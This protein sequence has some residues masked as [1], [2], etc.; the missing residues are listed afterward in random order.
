VA[1]EEDG[2]LRERDAILADARNGDR[3]LE[4]QGEDEDEDRGGSVATTGP[5]G[6]R[7][8]AHPPHSE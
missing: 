3:D 4:G 6:A 5:Q 8:L 7:I 1:V 2:E